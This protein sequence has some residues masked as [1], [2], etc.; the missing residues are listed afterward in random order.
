M[1]S[2]EQIEELTAE[3]YSTTDLIGI[4]GIESS[5]E[6][7]LTGDTTEHQG[8]QQVE[9]DS[10]GK[11]IRVLSTTPASDGDD[12]VL[13]LDLELQQVCETALERNIAEI[14][15]DQEEQIAENLEEY[16]NW[17]Q[18]GYRQYRPM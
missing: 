13:T 2:D 17:R 9:V 16:E 18:G 5:M 7:Y 14:R 4:S 8:S 1:Q 15:A 11:V 6:Q 3:G 12:V 10:S